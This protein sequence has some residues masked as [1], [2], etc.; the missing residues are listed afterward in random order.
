MQLFDKPLRILIP[1]FVH[2]ISVRLIRGSIP[3]TVAALA[4]RVPKLDNQ[5]KH[6]KRVRNLSAIFL[7]KHCKEG[8][9]WLVVRIYRFSVVNHKHMFF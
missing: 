1:K 7:T 2:L 9:F 8:G 4:R 3:Y 5:D 6:D